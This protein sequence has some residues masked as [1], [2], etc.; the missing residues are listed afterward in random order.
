MIE[1]RVTEA[2]ASL[3]DRLTIDEGYHAEMAY[4]CQAFAEVAKQASSCEH[5]DDDSLIPFEVL[6][7][8]RDLLNE[9]ARSE[10]AKAG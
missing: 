8:Y 3:I 2:V 6:A 10:Q 1:V 7:R 5:L 9:L 4:L